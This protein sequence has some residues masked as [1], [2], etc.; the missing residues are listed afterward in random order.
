MF[1]H[2]ANYHNNFKLP[3]KY[4]LIGKLFVMSLTIR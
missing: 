3:N 1:K 2:T 4:L